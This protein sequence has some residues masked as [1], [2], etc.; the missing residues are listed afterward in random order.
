[1]LAT[2]RTLVLCW[3]VL[4]SLFTH[5][6]SDDSDIDYLDDD[7]FED[8]HYEVEFKTFKKTPKLSLCSTLES[9]LPK[10]RIQLQIYAN[11]TE[12]KVRLR[13]L[14][15]SHTS[16]STLNKTL[17]GLTIDI[18]EDFKYPTSLLTID[19][20]QLIGPSVL[21]SLVASLVNTDLNLLSRNLKKTLIVDKGGHKQLLSCTGNMYP[22]QDVKALNIS[23]ESNKPLTC[24]K[25]P[26]SDRF[27]TLQ[28]KIYLLPANQKTFRLSEI[29]KDDPKK[30]AR[31]SWYTCNN[32]A[33]CTA[34]VQKKPL[35]D[36]TVNFALKFLQKP[37]PGKKAATG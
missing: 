12:E 27:F 21:Q 1:M 34:G 13:A 37:A 26:S 9:P 15:L 7:E 14:S 11:Y 17:I 33:A 20:Y 32:P 18:I 5:S 22:K 6:R 19:D 31:T 25:E 2:G 24:S 28:E 10:T 8:C 3:V 35:I 4:F 16:G 30:V 36:K 29:H 23:T